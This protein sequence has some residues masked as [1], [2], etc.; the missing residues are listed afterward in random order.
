MGAS[1]GA[2]STLLDIGEDAKDSPV[3]SRFISM[4]AL[5]QSPLASHAD[6]FKGS[7]RVPSGAGTRDEPLRTSAWEAKSQTRL[8][9][10]SLRRRESCIS[11]SDERKGAT[12]PS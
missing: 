3:S 8:S 1:A 5:S 10:L 6:V 7:S 11:K 9:R 2:S 4:C 12:W